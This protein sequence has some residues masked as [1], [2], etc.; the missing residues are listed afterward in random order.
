MNRVGLKDYLLNEASD[1][2][3][4]DCAKAYDSANQYG[5][6][7]TY[8]SVEEAARLCGW[9]VETALSESRHVESDAD[10]YRFNGY[11][12]LE[13]VSNESLLEDARDS[14]DDIIDWLEGASRY[15]LMDVSSDVE[16]FI[17]AE[18]P[19]EIINDV[20]C[21]ARKLGNDI[22]V[23][24]IRGQDKATLSFSKLDDIDADKIDLA[25]AA[26]A[27]VENYYKYADGYST[28]EVQAKFRNEHGRGLSAERADQLT[29]ACEKNMDAL[30]QVLDD[31]EIDALGQFF[32]V[33]LCSKTYC[34]TLANEAPG[35][36]YIASALEKMGFDVENGRAIEKHAD[37]EAKQ[38]FEF[39]AEQGG[40]FGE[41]SEYLGEFF[42]SGSVNRSEKINENWGNSIL[43]KGG[44]GLYDG[45]RG[46]I[47]VYESF[48]QAVDTSESWH[49]GDNIFADCEID[50]I[51]D[52][53]G[54]LFVTGAH[55]D[56]RALVE[57]RQL[58]D[59]GE[60][61]Y[62]GFQM[63]GGFYLPE[64]GFE[65]MGFVYR[66]GDE[67][68]FIHDLWDNPEMC[69]KPHFA[70]KV[71][72]FPT[73]EYI[74]EHDGVKTEFQ[75]SEIK[76]DSFAYDQGAR[77]DVKVLTDGHNCG[78]GHF[79]ADL[80]DAHGFCERFADDIA[81]LGESLDDMC[82]D[83]REVASISQDIDAGNRDQED[84]NHDNSE[85]GE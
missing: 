72:G 68:A 71:S 14:I 56:G 58:T 27:T 79:C 20:Y 60:D 54:S 1:S 74:M 24:L 65:T 29:A 66:E 81:G 36:K 78:Y 34:A 76:E 26:Y 25:N 3:L 38:R 44:N 18:D 82:E 70:E 30:K 2:D 77:F 63:D 55:H 53:N 4:L 45:P 73:E 28:E 41:V 67:N 32:D 42:G 7:D 75:I 13:A 62:S 10:C 8:D 22:E 69:S 5:H 85:I 80:D 33:E 37:L 57:M 64:D 52:E 11:G 59:K 84:K 35:C 23:E 16:L 61:L 50:G 43:V 12:H 21:S 49:G 15:E 46:G 19:I 6:F 83:R 47:T 51:W 31:D 17:D 9:D 39:D 40:D 48:E